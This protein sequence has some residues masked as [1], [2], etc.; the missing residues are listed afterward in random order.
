MSKSKFKLD[1]KSL[2]IIYTA[3]IRPVHKYGDV[4]WD[5]CTEY[6]NNDLDLF[7]LWEQRSSTHIVLL[8]RFTGTKTE[9]IIDLL[10][11]KNDVSYYPTLLVQSSTLDCCNISRYNLHNSYDLQLLLPGLV[12]TIT[13][14]YLQ[15]P[16]SLLCSVLRPR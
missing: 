3:F 4:I 2:K 8:L 5:I 16:E 11:L 10:Y 15:Q 7:L 1:R 12:S 13:L 6:E 14:F 9:K